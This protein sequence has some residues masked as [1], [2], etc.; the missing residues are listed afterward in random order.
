MCSA[1]SCPLLR[2][3]RLHTIPSLPSFSQVAEQRVAGV[4]ARF[5]VGA[6][7]G[8][9][10][11]EVGALVLAQLGIR[12]VAALDVDLVDLRGAADVGLGDDGVLEDGAVQ[13]RELQVRLVHVRARHVREAQVRVEERRRAQVRAAEVGV[14]NQRLLEAHA[15]QVLPAEVAAVQRRAA[16]DGLHRARVEPLGGRRALCDL[17]RARTRRAGRVRLAQAPRGPRLRHRAADRAGAQR[18]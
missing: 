15:A 9:E 3:L 16:R 6:L 2:G 14:A 10:L 8:V 13:A 11:A 5:R 4:D 12:P 18:R 7:R 17:G 1:R